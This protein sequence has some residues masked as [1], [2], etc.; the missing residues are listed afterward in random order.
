MLPNSGFNLITHF[1]EDLFILWVVHLTMEWK[2]GGTQSRV[3]LIS[4]KN[5]RVLNTVLTFEKS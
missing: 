2:K 3:L 1:N 5:S 4:P